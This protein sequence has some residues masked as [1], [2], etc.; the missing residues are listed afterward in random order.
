MKLK[1]DPPW[2][3]RVPTTFSRTMT[4][5]PRSSLTLRLMSF[6]NGL[7]VPLRSPSK[8]APVPANERSWHGNEAH[9]KHG[10]P[11]KS[12]TL[13]LATSSTLSSGDS[14]K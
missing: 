6:Q 1:S 13:I 5:G 14:P 10:W 9:A 3:I 2:D 7:N 12:P 8:P 11:G 4:F